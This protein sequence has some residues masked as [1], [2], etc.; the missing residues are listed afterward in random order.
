MRSGPKVRIPDIRVCEICN[1]E[2]ACKYSRNVH[3]KRQHP[4]QTL[5]EEEFVFNCDLCTH[6]AHSWKDF[7]HH[8]SDVHNIQQ[9]FKLK[10][11]LQCLTSYNP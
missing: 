7:Y 1:F 9:E 8:L 5:P 10:K 2:F 11:Q 4:V 6:E 3:M